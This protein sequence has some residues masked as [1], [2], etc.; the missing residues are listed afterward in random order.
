MAG[1]IE[2]NTPCPKCKELTAILDVG[3][4]YEE[5]SCSDEKCA[6]YH[7][8]EL[9][10]NSYQ[11]VTSTSKEEQTDSPGSATQE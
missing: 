9:N 5:L 2:F 4:S 11:L 3:K 10:N 1:F 7:Y 8:Y 6:Y